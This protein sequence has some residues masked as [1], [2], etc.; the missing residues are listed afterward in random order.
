VPK[1]GKMPELGRRKG[2]NILPKS[3]LLT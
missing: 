1:F 3:T 2:Q